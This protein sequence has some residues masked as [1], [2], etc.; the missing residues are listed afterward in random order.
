MLMGVGLEQYELLR[1]PLV[2]SSEN[3]YS[4]HSGE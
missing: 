4:T 1:T 3:S 2:R